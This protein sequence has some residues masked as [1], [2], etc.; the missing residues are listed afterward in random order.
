MLE[1]Y[2][3]FLQLHRREQEEAQYWRDVGTLEAFYEANM[4]LVSVSPVFN[5]YDEH[6]PI[7]TYQRSIH[8]PSLS[9]RKPDAW[10]KRSIRWWFRLHR[11]GGSVQNCV[12]LRTCA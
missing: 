12:L 3:V 11:L 1:D 2:R 9:L 5:L 8:L 10:A 6:W 4:D 7:R